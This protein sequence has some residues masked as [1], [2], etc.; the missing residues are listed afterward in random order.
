MTKKTK[1]QI[2]KN[3]R[4]IEN[5]LR[6]IGNTLFWYTE[7]PERK[8]LELQAQK[9]MDE[10]G[11]FH[12]YKNGN[13]QDYKKGDIFIREEDWNKIKENISNL[14]PKRLN[15]EKPPKTD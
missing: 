1:P 13:D 5:K 2:D 8:R 4:K 7:V 6:E 10:I 12:Y 11:A 3:L 9:I 14:F 15:T